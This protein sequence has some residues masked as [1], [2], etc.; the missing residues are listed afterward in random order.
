MDCES[1]EARRASKQQFFAC[2]TWEEFLRT[3]A[4]F[5][6]NEVC[7]PTYYDVFINNESGD[8]PQAGA[9]LAQLFVDITLMSCIVTDSQVALPNQQ[10][11]YAL[12]Y[13]PD[14]IS[15]A[16]YVELNRYD[17][18][19]AILNNSLSDNDEARNNRLRLPYVT[20]N[21]WNNENG[22]IMKGS[23]QTHL[24]TGQEGLAVI[25]EWLNPSMKKRI[26]PA[27]FDEVIVLD[28]NTTSEELRLFR[29]LKECLNTV[30]RQNRLY[31]AVKDGDY[32]ALKK[33]LSSEVTVASV[34]AQS[35]IYGKTGVSMIET[36]VKNGDVR[37]INILLQYMRELDVNLYQA[38]LKRLVQKLGNEAVREKVESKLP[39]W[40]FK[41]MDVEPPL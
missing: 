27:H 35:S 18:V 19:S 17:G 11:A 10:K 30:H 38:R 28:A 1:K 22:D 6:T 26:S 41:E 13:V 2:D 40:Y 29:V 8:N 9:E 31:L 25:A 39:A 34:D 36:A 32:G 24:A 33:L 14:Q 21:N 37:M 12:C 3:W 23:P 15:R 7:I 5:Y 4:K 20:Y 16:L